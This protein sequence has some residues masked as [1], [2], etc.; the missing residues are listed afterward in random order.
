[1]DDPILL[2]RSRLQADQFPWAG[3]A[4]FIVTPSDSLCAD[5]R[6]PNRL[7]HRFVAA[8]RQMVSSDNQVAKIASLGC[9]QRFPPLSIGTEPYVA[10]GQIVEDCC[11]VSKEMGQP[12]LFHGLQKPCDV[13]HLHRPLAGRQGYRVV[14]SVG[15]GMAYLTYRLPIPETV[16]QT[17]RKR[18]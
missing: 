8:L 17:D 9:L 10:K 3:D 2:V 6:S 13:N 18:D 15:D 16:A 1:G 5:D 11:L 12:G 7:D 14:S 4:E